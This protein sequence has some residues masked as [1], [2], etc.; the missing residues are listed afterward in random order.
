MDGGR[1]L[2]WSWDLVAIYANVIMQYLS[3]N[4]SCNNNE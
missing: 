3:H 4:N 2:Y 1:M